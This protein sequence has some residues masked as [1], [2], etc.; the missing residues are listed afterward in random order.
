MSVYLLH[1]E[2]PGKKHEH[3]LGCT[4]R[5]VETRL[6]EHK[7]GSTRYTKMLKQRGYTPQIAHVWPDGDFAFE[8]KVKKSRAVSLTKLCPICSGRIP[9]DK[10]KLEHL[11]SL[12][13]SRK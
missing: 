8:K 12:H 10:K 9:S 2:A 7:Q 4:T 13:P 3:Y 1:F 6:K 11:I 5:S